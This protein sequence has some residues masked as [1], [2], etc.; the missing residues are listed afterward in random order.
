M[1][2]QQS[3]VRTSESESLLPL[4]KKYKRIVCRLFHCKESNITILINI[5]FLYIGIGYF[6][7]SSMMFGY[8]KERGGVLLD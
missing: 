2:L 1:A 4:H 7:L 6:Y 3:Y 8:E 5:F